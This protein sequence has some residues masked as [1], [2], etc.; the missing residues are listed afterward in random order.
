M[1][2]K[3]KPE[4][5]SRVVSLQTMTWGLTPFAGLV[6]GQM[7]DAWGAP[8]VVGAWMAVAAGLTLVITFGSREMRRI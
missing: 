1:Q 5:R 4:Y 3:A 2:M 6:M 8:N 7:I